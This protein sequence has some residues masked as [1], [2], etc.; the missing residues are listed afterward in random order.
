MFNNIFV[1]PFAASD[2]H[3]AGGGQ[4]TSWPDRLNAPPSRLSEL[5]LSPEV[6]EKDTVI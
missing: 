1:Q 5:G 4:L 2:D 6:F 3:K